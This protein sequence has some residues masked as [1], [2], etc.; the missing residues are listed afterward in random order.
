MHSLEA[1]ALNQDPRI[2]QAK[3]LILSAL[4]EHRSRLTG[5]R[6]PLQEL[7]V[8][9]DEL[10][11]T[12]GQ[13]RGSKLYYPYLGSGLGNGSL[14][15][16]LDGSVKYD[17]ISGIGTHYWGHSH[18]D[19]V[20]ASL[21]A[22]LSDS[23]MQGNLQ[24]NR[25]T[26]DISQ[27]LVRASGLDH[28]ILTTSGAMANEN[29]LKLAFQ[30]NYPADRILAFNRCFMGRTY[31]LCQI[32]DKPQYREQLPLTIPVDY[33]PF[34]D[35]N[36]PEES[37]AATIR[38]LKK[39]LNRYPKRHAVMC[40]ELIQGE[41]GF[42]VGHRD[43]FAPLMQICRDE[44]IAVLVDEVQSFGRTPSLFAY[45][46]FG[47]QEWV[48]I[49]TIGK[50]TQICA[51]LFRTHY[52]PR[53]GLISQTFTGSTASIRA[54]LVIVR[55]LIQGNYLGE[56]GIIAQIGRQMSANLQ[57]LVSRYP[58]RIQGPFGMGTMVAFTPWGG[59]SQTVARY[60]QELF[61]AGVIGFT[62]GSQPSRARLLIPAG[63]VKPDDLDAVTAI[64]EQV[65]LQDPP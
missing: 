17:F 41:A 59:T 39:H 38:A 13:L 16:L 3:Q 33:L 44:G 54:A 49:V 64:I 55:G 57:E 62:A 45:Q 15:E 24:Q 19:L 36:Q 32:T 9:Y 35:A 10:I 63:A 6:P 2:A 48:D 8:S 34:Y 4:A 7:T 27:E 22:A 53:A 20:A 25:D 60:M 61:T 30:K 52:Q 37:C 42:H 58:E 51:T 47:L 40:F 56:E 50:L 5:I 18:P 46:Y 29:A 12:L 23:V 43:F 65:L 14:V 1:D 26:L 11:K 21:D 31:A 28:C